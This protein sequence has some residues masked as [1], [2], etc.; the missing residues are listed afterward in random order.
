MLNGLSL[1]KKILPNSPDF[2][3]APAFIPSELSTGITRMVESKA[4]NI[5]QTNV[6]A[7]TNRVLCPNYVIPGLRTL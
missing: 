1:K 6:K 5:K 7:K 3:S 4:E 2:L